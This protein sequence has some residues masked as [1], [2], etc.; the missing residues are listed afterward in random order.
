VL[1]SRQTNSPAS[2]LLFSLASAIRPTQNRPGNAG[3]GPI[4]TKWNLSATPT[5]YA[6]DHKGMIRA[7]WAGPPGEKVMDAALN[8]L[9]KT[10]EKV[11]E[12]DGRP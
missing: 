5:F 8:R 12:G 9:I 2:V 6:L 3:A 7:K 10:A 1:V 11:G 4:A